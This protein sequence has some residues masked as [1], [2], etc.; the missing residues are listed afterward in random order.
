MKEQINF[1]DAV[2]L[3]MIKEEV[4][5]NEINY[6][7]IF[8]NR[9]F[10]YIRYVGPSNK[11]CIISV[12][13]IYGFSNKL[14]ILHNIYNQENYFYQPT[15]IPLLIMNRG[16]LRDDHENTNY[17]ENFV[18]IIN[19][20]KIETCANTRRKFRGNGSMAFPKKSYNL[21]FTEKKTFLNFPS[22]SKKCILNFKLC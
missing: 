2:P 5:L 6:V 16:Y 15:N 20:N 22:K 17:L 21:K 3:Y 14:N 13:K 10:R 9:P 12:I 18:Y 4:K 19:D 11:K 7:D 8:T 1:Y